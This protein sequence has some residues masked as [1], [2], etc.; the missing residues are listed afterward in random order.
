MA[1]ARRPTARCRERER[2]R[3]RPAAFYK[4]DDVRALC[5]RRLSTGAHFVRVFARL[6]TLPSIFFCCFLPVSLF[7]AFRRR[8]VARSHVARL[9]PVSALT[10]RRSLLAFLERAPFRSCASPLQCNQTAACFLLHFHTFLRC[11]NF[12]LLVFRSSIQ[13]VRGL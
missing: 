9:P 13:L 4:V 5:R 11:V 1:A 8:I 3:R 7:A 2:R 6:T 12:G 10:H